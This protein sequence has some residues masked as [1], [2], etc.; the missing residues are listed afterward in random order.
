MGWSAVAVVT[1]KIENLLRDLGFEN[2]WKRRHDFV[3]ADQDPDT[4]RG[5]QIFWNR[6]QGPS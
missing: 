4:E 3:E 1:L 2:S 6:R 5:E